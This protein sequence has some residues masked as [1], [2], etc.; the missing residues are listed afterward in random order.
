MNSYDINVA[1]QNYLVAPFLKMCLINQKAYLELGQTSTRDVHC[2]YSFINIFWKNIVY[3][4][5]I[6]FFKVLPTEK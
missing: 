1:K 4:K 6:K 5:L 2:R 3:R